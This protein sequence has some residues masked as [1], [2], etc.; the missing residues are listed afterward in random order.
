MSRG[1]KVCPTPGCPTLIPRGDRACGPCGTAR[2]RDRG[3]STARGYGADHRAARAEAEPTVIGK[4]C[5]R[6][7]L[8][9]CIEPAGRMIL[10]GQPWHMD[11]DDHDRTRYIGPSHA[12]CNVA[13]GGKLAHN[14]RSE[15]G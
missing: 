11:H 14:P 1:R 12:G 5:A 10:P 8:G 13:A 7:P 9:Q 15:G 6:Y 2:E 4:T 3:S